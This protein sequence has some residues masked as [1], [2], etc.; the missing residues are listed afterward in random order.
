MTTIIKIPMVP[1]SPE[2]FGNIASI[3][4]TAIEA[5]VVRLDAGLP[6]GLPTETVY[7]LAAGCDQW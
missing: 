7:G 6:V 4:K 1:L 2:D 3:A 5:A